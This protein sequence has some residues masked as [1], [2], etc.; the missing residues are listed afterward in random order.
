[1]RW[2]LLAGLASIGWGETLVSFE[3]QTLS[4]RFFSEGACLADIDSDGQMDV[5]SG[6]FWYAGPDFNQRHAFAEPKA[7]R[8][9]EYS[10][11]FFTFTHDFDGDGRMDILGI[12]AP[13]ETAHW[14]R[15][16][17][18]RK[19]L[20]S[21]Y[22][23]FSGVDNESPHFTDLTGDG[24][25]ELVCCHA[26]TIGYASP[27]W[28]Q[29]K[30]KWTFTAVTENRG[31][32]RYTHGLGIG[33]VNE[34]GRMDVLETNGWWEQ[35]AMP[36]VFVFHAVA[37]AEAGGAQM[38][39]SDFDGDGDNDVV[40]SQN[41][42]AWGLTWFENTGANDSPEFVPHKITTRRPEDN[43]YGVA[44]SQMHAL[45]L[46]DM[47]GDG[48]DD[49]ITGKRYFAH[50]GKDPGA[51][52]LPVLYW[53]RTVRS[54]NGV[55]FEP[56][57]AD[58]RSGVGT[59]L[60]VGDCNGDGSPD[61][62]IG[63]KL[64]TYVVR[65]FR[66]QVS[67]SEYQ[68]RRPEK[69]NAPK[70]V[71]GT[72]LFTSHV[73]T[74]EALTARQ[75]LA[76]FS[77]PAGFEIQLV[78]SEPDIDKPLNMAF[79]ARGRLWVTTT[80]EYP[81]AAPLDRPGRDSIRVLE[82]TTGDGKADKIIT[83]AEGLNIPI[84]L[85]PYQDGVICYSIPNIWFLRDTDGDGQCD[86]REK[87]YGP[88][89]YERDTHGMC[90]GF[91][92][93]LDGWLYA[94]HGFN[95]RTTLAG[96][97]GHQIEMQSGNIFRMRTD[98]SRVEL[99]TRGQVNPF[100]MGFSPGG[101]AFTADCHTRPVSLLLQGGYHESFGKPN[102]GLGFIPNMMEHSHGSTAISG[103]AFGS[104]TTFPESYKDS[105]FAGNVTTCRIN[106][107]RIE[108]RESSPYAVE[109]PDFLVSGDPW[110]RPVDLQ[111]G[112]DG[113]L[114]VAD[115]YN[116][117]I[118][119]YEVP[120][121]HAGRD[122]HRGRIWRITYTGSPLQRTP[123]LESASLAKLIDELGSPL[124][125]RADLA[126]EQTIERFGA[127]AVESLKSLLTGTNELAT[128][129][130]LWLLYRLDALADSDLQNAIFHS[131]SHVREHAYRIMAEQKNGGVA[132]LIIRGLED[133]SARV[134]RA[135]A[136]AASRC[137]SPE[138]PAP[139]LKLL[140]SIRK[141][142]QLRYAT[143][144]ALRNHLRT[145]EWFTM[146]TESETNK[147]SIVELAGLC[148]A[149]PSPYAGRFVARHLD[150]LPTDDPTQL[151][152]WI[153][154]AAHHA[155]SKD[156]EFVVD[157]A[158]SKI[159][160]NP[161]SQF[162][163][164]TLLHEGSAAK[165]GH[166]PPS[167]RG[168]ATELASTLLEDDGLPEPLGWSFLPD[169]YSGNTENPWTVSSRR[170]ASDGEKN[171]SLWSSFPKGEQRRGVFRSER[172]TLPESFVFFLAGHDGAPPQPVR[173]RNLVRLCDAESGEVLCS[174]IP[175]R[176][177]IAQEVRWNTASH[178]GRS[179]YIELVDGDA[180]SAY[181]WLAAG[182]FSVPGL[183]PSLIPLKRQWAAELVE[184]FRLKE[185]RTSLTGVLKKTNPSSQTAVVCARAVA[186][187]TENH[188]ALASVVPILRVEALDEKHK[189]FAIA[190]LI[191]GSIEQL[192]V[193]V[194]EAMRVA[195]ATAR[196]QIAEPLAKQRESVALLL[197]LIH[198]GTVS[199]ELL[200][201]PR[202]APLLQATTNTE[203]RVVIKT[204]LE[205][206]PPV[207]TALQSRINSLVV[208]AKKSGG[209]IDGG[210]AI[211]ETQCMICHQVGGKGTALAPNLDGIGNRGLERLAEDILDPNR[212]VDE[213]FRVT[214]LVKTNG[215]ALTGFI[216]R[217]NKT[218]IIVADAAGEEEAI[219][220]REI[221]SREM[222]RY[223]LMPSVFSQTLDETQF[224]DL[225]AWL[226]SL[227]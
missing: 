10:P 38:F 94:C 132:R 39:V 111:A 13:G 88:L 54:D 118:G 69:S 137:L 78:A 167:V 27:N 93:H 99:F 70:H 81:Y 188:P 121:D 169:P 140:K 123:N 98:G 75:E 171:V 36:G 173:N 35:P 196:I 219:P 76:S 7:F 61:V 175:P 86:R 201:H 53:F 156:I 87:L 43:P 31:Y 186:A 195:P 170:N 60:T 122:R 144:L 163:F 68:R 23:A 66:K 215:E 192:S 218:S 117:I 46:A 224:R 59:Q 182:R 191:G 44:L 151:R 210:K 56:W 178:R 206:L 74:T 165:S 28:N 155:P 45:A 91:T 157:H 105:V 190:A 194:T 52:E 73:R 222:T 129:R 104:A 172:F 48:V 204:L 216:R 139:L 17:G 133:Q 50:G 138:L 8:I 149:I 146:L 6:P 158:R 147:R 24:K 5:V 113:A 124:Q 220:K 71:P 135:A 226:L 197:S 83:F 177:D 112:P 103:I 181:A 3:K 1:M 153:V 120:L 127:K 211:F 142:P 33:D 63:N 214:T 159:G 9:K 42:H 25:P 180:G 102:D 183:N 30:E 72:D 57:L 184:R 108:Y 84:G 34:D 115:F 92:R 205:N 80:L 116:R 203:Q 96:S 168:W 166:L 179:V 225:M 213:A 15:N 21:A 176:N 152:D 141:D 65:S 199:P 128:G 198:P 20:W 110:F 136:M 185:F 119:H 90:N 41:A 62:I 164:L 101:E 14:Y 49:V 126:V 26:G 106:R 16:P 19:E 209:K 40:S 187:I 95:N 29:P 162:D 58:P 193:P 109:E 207:D 125:T 150:Q 143:R 208:A 202:L 100:G 148:V 154:F 131:N 82:D 130:A 223:S 174:A 200:R 227:R 212:N 11:F 79:D 217:Q 85:Y 32:Q 2:M 221:R 145:K 64:G 51:H 161:K 89:G 55:E 22:P 67:A 107:N 18:P 47:D 4:E 134:R 160:E 12:S 77:L 37:F 97:D 189:R 114:Y